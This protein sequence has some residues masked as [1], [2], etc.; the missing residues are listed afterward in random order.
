M[1]NLTLCH[2]NYIII[3]CKPF[4]FTNRPHIMLIAFEGFFW[5]VLL[6]NLIA[7]TIGRSAF[8]GFFW[9]VL[10]YNLIAWTIGRSE[11]VFSSRYVPF[12]RQR[13]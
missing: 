6:Y 2:N 1:N 11:D 12:N 9:P 7:W 4:V 3:L 10:L 13:G 5:P 8:E